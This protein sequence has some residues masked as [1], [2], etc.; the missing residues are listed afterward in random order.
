VYT[1]TQ[2]TRIPN[3]PHISLDNPWLSSRY[4]MT[5]ID[6]K[7]WPNTA[8]GANAGRSLDGSAAAGG[9]VSWVLG[10]LEQRHP[11]AVGHL[12]NHPRPGVCM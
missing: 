11:L 10:A 1:R 6:S 4:D 3:Y 2:L 7:P 9:G 8:H 5:I 12:I